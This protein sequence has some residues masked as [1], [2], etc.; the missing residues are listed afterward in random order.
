VVEV[1]SPKELS[2]KARA[3]IDRLNDTYDR[4]QGKKKLTPREVAA[5]E[6]AVD[7]LVKKV[8]ADPD[9]FEGLELLD[10]EAVISLFTAAF[11]TMLR[12]MAEGTLRTL[13]LGSDEE[14]DEIPES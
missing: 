13:G 6:Q 9:D 1:V 8:L 2:L 14:E 10:K 4:L 12:R 3:E 11:G 7:G 5:M